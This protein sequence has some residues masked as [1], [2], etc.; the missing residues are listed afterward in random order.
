MVPPE[1]PPKIS[2]SFLR[3]LTYADYLHI[4][5]QRPMSRVLS[6]F[7]PSSRN[8]DG[9]APPMPKSSRSKSSKGKD[10]E[11]EKDFEAQWAKGDWPDWVRNGEY[12]YE[13]RTLME[14]GY[15]K[16]RVVEALEVNDFNLMQATE[17]LLSS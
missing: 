11:K 10:K 13:R 15:H 7:R 2:A 1:R 17:Y 16:D 14:M 12:Q 8:M 4:V 9:G 5:S 6:I 3:P